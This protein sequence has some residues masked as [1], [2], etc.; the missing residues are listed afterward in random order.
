[1]NW[2]VI[3]YPEVLLIY[4]EAAN[5]FYGPNSEVLEAVNK[6]RR[7]AN[8]PELSGLSKQQLREA[9]WREKWHELCYEGKIWFDMVRIRK[10]FNPISRNFEDYVGH[11]FVYGP[12]LQERELLYPIPGPEI[13]NNENLSQNPGY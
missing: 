4:A 12:T 3:R 8:I 9:I 5:E 7:R 13:R 1:M 10:A 6:I 11:K 2:P